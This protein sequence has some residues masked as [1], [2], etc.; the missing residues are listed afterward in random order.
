MSLLWLSCQMEC[1]ILVAQEGFKPA[2]LALEGRFL[3]NGLQGKALNK[4]F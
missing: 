2:S 4:P 3:T 1:G